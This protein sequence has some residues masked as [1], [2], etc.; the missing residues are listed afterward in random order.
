MT[1]RAAS[2]FAAAAS[3]SMPPSA[4]ALVAAAAEA[5]LLPALV[6]VLEL[7]DGGEQAETAARAAVTAA[8]AAAVAARRRGRAAAAPRGI[9]RIWGTFH[10][11][12]RGPGGCREERDGGDGRSQ[13]VPLGT[14]RHLG[15]ARV[16]VA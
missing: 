9:R 8:R 3:A 11:R 6:D 13:G 14:Y 7:L 5:P 15:V 1:L 2:L 16:N 4:C 10:E 12:A